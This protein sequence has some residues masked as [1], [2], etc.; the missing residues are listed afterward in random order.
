MRCFW[1][2]PKNMGLRDDVQFF[3]IHDQKKG[4]GAI[5]LCVA[6]GAHYQEEPVGACV[7]MVI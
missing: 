2:N 7:E 5:S 4:D 6:R 3:K 1:L